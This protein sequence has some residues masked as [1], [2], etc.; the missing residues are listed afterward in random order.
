MGQEPSLLSQL[1]SYVVLKGGG[2][3]LPSLLVPTLVGII[4]YPG[5]V[6]VPGLKAYRRAI[7]IIIGWP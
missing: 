5:F 7:G 2:G 1:H 6:C 4:I 3:I